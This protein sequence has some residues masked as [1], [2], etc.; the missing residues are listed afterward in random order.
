M[1]DLGKAYR[2]LIRRYDELDD[3]RNGFGKKSWLA[4][5]IKRLFSKNKEAMIARQRGIKND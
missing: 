5:F 2:R 4:S 3:L 1:N